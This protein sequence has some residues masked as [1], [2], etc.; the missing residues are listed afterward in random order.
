[1]IQL[2]AITIHLLF[3]K[4]YIAE[5]LGTFVLTLVVLLSSG[6]YFSIATPLLAGLVL[7]LFVY[8]IGHISGSHL[9]PAV[10]IGMWSIGK[11]DS[12]DAVYY[13]VVQLV[14]ALFALFLG[15]QFIVLPIVSVSPSLLV[16]IAEAFG[17]FFF[18][19]GIASIVY[20]KAPHHMSGVVIGGSLLL[21]IS[22]ASLIGSNGIINPAVALGIRSFGCMYVLGPIIG[23]I[24]GMN[25]YKYLAKE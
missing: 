8:S 10:T 25:L 13:I 19:F 6:G 11:I 21:G 17:T 12:V 9:N 24:L 3:M 2:Y 14:G 20:G 22:I 5:G 4:K 7:G 15:S 23:S 18:T 1:M 16:G